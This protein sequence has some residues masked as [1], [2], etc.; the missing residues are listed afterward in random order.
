VDYKILFSGALSKSEAVNGLSMQVNVAIDAGWKPLGGVTVVHESWRDEKKLHRRTH[1]MLP[2]D[3]EGEMK[4]AQQLRGAK[5]FERSHQ[6][7]VCDRR[8]GVVSAGESFSVV[9]PGL[10]A[11]EERAHI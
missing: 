9:R 7:T 3:G 11:L 6:F 1:D 10:S 5:P 8:G 2:G 4:M